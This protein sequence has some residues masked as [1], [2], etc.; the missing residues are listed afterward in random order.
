MGK[1]IPRLDPWP[2]GKPLPT[3]GLFIFYDPDSNQEYR[4]LPEQ[5]GGSQDAQL[6]A[7]ALPST[8]PTLVSFAMTPE[9]TAQLQ[10]G[11]LR[12]VLLPISLPPTTGGGTTTPG[13]GT[14]TPPDSSTNDANG[15]S[16][17]S[18]W[19]TYGDSYPDSY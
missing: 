9:T 12:L 5:V 7:V 1:T 17:A 4:V 11:G 16:T 3:K 18:G 13:G 10:A 2:L 19:N 6:S 14:T 15:Y 8:D